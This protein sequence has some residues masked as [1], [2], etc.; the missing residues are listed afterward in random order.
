MCRGNET[1]RRISL[2]NEL[3]ELSRLANWVGDSG[4]E[5]GFPEETIFDLTLVLE[6]V[7]S[8]I[9]RHG[10]GKRE[11]GARRIDVSIA[12][13]GRKI[14]VEVSDDAKPFNPLEKE[15]PDLN[16]P[17]GERPNGGLGIHLVRR[18]MD[19]LEYRFDRGRNVLMLKKWRSANDADH[20]PSND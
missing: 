3:S 2:K 19:E 11:V 8:N 10:Y 12:W 7:V 14:C 13:T 17:F 1:L 15:P 18:L 6:E 16:L 9:V 5:A 20:I 4:M